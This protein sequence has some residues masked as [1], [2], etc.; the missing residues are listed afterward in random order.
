MDNYSL[1][2]ARKFRWSSITGELNP[3]RIAHLDR[4]L[5]GDLF[6]DAGCAGGA[7]SEY[8][9]AKGFDV[10]GVDKMLEFLETIPVDRRHFYKQADVTDLP[11]EDNYFDSTYCFDVLEHVDDFTALK[12]LVRVTKRRL[13]ITVPHE[14]YPLFQK[15]NLTLLTYQDSTHLRYYNAESLEKLIRSVTDSPFKIFGELHVPIRSL[16]SELIKGER[17][18]SFNYAIRSI[19]AFSFKALLYTMKDSDLP[20]YSSLVAIVDL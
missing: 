9:R 6:L 13:I 15:C 20:F 19:I 2:N 11:F 18:S 1:E 3:E 17:K 8:L 12:E 10:T 14:N 7:Y 16:C 4:Y 5:L